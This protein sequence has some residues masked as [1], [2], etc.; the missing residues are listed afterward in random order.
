MNRVMAI[1]ARWQAWAIGAFILL[2]TAVPGCE[3][4]TAGALDETRYCGIENIVRNADGSI[5]RR[6]D[7]L[8][9]FRAA[10]P[11]PSTGLT[12]GA[13]PNW[14]LDHVWPLAEGGCDSVAN[15][16]WLPNAIKSCAASVNPYCKDRWERVVYKPRPPP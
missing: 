12:S 14:S 15:L 4:A 1:G 7:V 16:Q 11:C 9:A 2:A 10:V 13:C 3:P 8:R 5:R 6:A